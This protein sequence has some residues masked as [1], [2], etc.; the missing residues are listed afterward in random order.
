MAR[1]SILEHSDDDDYGYG[2]I[3]KEDMGSSNRPVEDLLADRQIQITK[4]AHLHNVDIPENNML[5]EAASG[6]TNSGRAKFTQ[7]LNLAEEGRIRRLFAPQ[8]DRLMRVEMSDA[9][10]IFKAFVAGRILLITDSQIWNFADPD[11]EY[12]NGAQ[13]YHAAIQARQTSLETSHKLKENNKI[14]A[15]RGVQMS[16]QSSYGIEWIPAVYRNRKLIQQGYYRIVEDEWKTIELVFS[17][18][19]KMGARRVATYFTE[20]ASTERWP[21]TPSGTVV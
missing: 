16:G 15:P 1:Q 14:R 20:L 9:A 19:P 21:L 17:L 6:T 8:F 11:F 7:L 5:L 12:K 2:R 13:F 3:S 4:L 18:I 10:D